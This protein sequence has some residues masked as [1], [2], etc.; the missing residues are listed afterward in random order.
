MKKNPLYI[1]NGSNI[2]FATDYYDGTIVSLKK[3][4]KFIPV[5]EPLIGKREKELI[6]EGLDTGWISSE[7]PFVEKFEKLGK[8]I[9]FK[10]NI[11]KQ[12]LYLFSSNLINTFKK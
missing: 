1:G 7:G 12:F 4:D 8:S 11:I 5:N 9:T 6:N 2:C 10:N 3:M